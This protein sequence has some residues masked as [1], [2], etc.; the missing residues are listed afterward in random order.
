[1]RTL[2]SEWEMTSRLP[3]HQHLPRL[4]ESLVDNQKESNA[5]R[6]DSRIGIYSIRRQPPFKIGSQREG[7]SGLKE[8]VNVT[9]GIMKMA[10]SWPW[11]KDRATAGETVSRM[12]G[13]GGAGSR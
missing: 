6:L 11:A 5:A 3:T 13:S 7:Y 10:L 2:P 12:D 8:L 9:I 1:M 4:M